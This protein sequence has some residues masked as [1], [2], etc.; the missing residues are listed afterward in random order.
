MGCCRRIGRVARRG[1]ASRDELSPVEFLAIGD[2]N[3]RAIPSDAAGRAGAGPRA[4]HSGGRSGSELD[5]GADT[6]IPGYRT[7]PDTEWIGSELKRGVVTKGGWLSS[8]AGQ[9]TGST[10]PVRGRRF[11]AGATTLIQAIGHARECSRKVDAWLSGVRRLPA[12]VMAGPVF[13]SKVAG[14][15]DTG[16]HADECDSDPRH[17]DAAGRRTHAGVGSRDRVFRR[18]GVRGSV[19]VLS[20]PLQIRDHRR[21]MRPLR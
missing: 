12:R 8:G 1:G 7:I 2:S 5:I 4:A 6:V 17:A 3:W 21:E 11:C 16:R 18:Y 13:Q 9:D 10:Q 14:G 19:A 15:R 20:V